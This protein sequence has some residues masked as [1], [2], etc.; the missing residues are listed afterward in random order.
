MNYSNDFERWARECVRIT[1]KETG[2]PVPFVLNRPQRRVLAVMERQRLAR[3]PIR[4]IMLKARQWG[5]STLVQIYMA[6]LQLCVRTDWSSVICA[7]VKDAAAGIRGM[8]SALLRDYPLKSEEWSAE[9][10]EERDEKELQKAWTLVPYEKSQSVSWLAARRCRIALA[11]AG[12]P[13]ALRGGNYAMAHLS[14]VAFWGDGDKETAEKIVR[15]VSGSI[16]RVPDSLVVMESTA[17]GRDSYFHEE[18]RRAVEGKSDKTAVFVPWHEIEI[19][20][21]ELPADPAEREKVI[22]RF[23]AYERSLLEQGVDAEAVAWYHE[24]RREY[25][26]HQAM[27]AEFPSTPEEAFANTGDNCPFLDPATLPTG[28][29]FLR[30]SQKAFNSGNVSFGE[31]HHPVLVAAVPAARADR[32]AAVV[33]ANENGCLRVIKELETEGTMPRFAERVARECRRLGATLVIAEAVREGEPGHAAWFARRAEALGV[34]IGYDEEERPW[35]AASGE[36]LASMLDAHH[37]LVADGRFFEG[38]EQSE[39]SESSEFSDNSEPSEPSESVRNL[40]QGFR[41]DAPQRCPRV[42]ARIA[43]AH[44]AANAPRPVSIDELLL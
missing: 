40:Y 5:G 13:D 39:E 22:G 41:T 2:A 18:W 37:Q 29:E 9:S 6:W 14:E 36:A 11:T 31:T 8:Y 3:R 44:Y 35:T 25:P 32:R 26:T 12:S 42:L 1:D 17:N 7:H 38:S 16:A 23:D 30:N 15:T 33:L 4:I 27:M 24:K 10:G 28:G 21:T 20:R 43:A 34:S 19:Y